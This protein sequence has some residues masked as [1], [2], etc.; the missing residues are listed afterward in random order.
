MKVFRYFA[1][2]IFALCA[3]SIVSA[4]QP[5][6]WTT[7]SVVLESDNSSWVRMARLKDGNWL[8][9]YTVYN[10]PKARIRIKKSLDNMR[11]WQF[12]TEVGEDG[13]D[14]DNPTLCVRQDGAVLLALRSVVVN[15]GFSFYINTYVSN[16]AGNSFAYQSQVEWDHGN[17]GV[18][19]PYLYALPDGKILCFYTSEIH[20]REPTPYSQILAEKVS[21]D[22]GSTWGPEIFAISQPGAARP[23]EANIVAL[24]GSVLALFYEICATENCVGH[25]SYS[26]DGVTWPGIGPAL[27]HTFQDV[28]AVGLDN[29]IIVATSNSKE[30]IVSVDYTNSWIDTKFRPFAAGSWPA[31]Y[32][33]GPNEISL[34]YTNGDDRERPGAFIRFGTINP[35]AIQTATSPG[36][37]RGPS[38]TRPQNCY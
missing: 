18:Y 27:A 7:Q 1:V 8:A 31:I 15:P 2:V 12:V 34:A 23:G 21:T 26:T 5:I 22:G 33:T 17:G 6:T 9:A 36:T 30:V 29:G 19:E 35:A 3:V 14:L 11:T 20:Q 16:D 32:Q 37:C 24:P 13:R 4:Q 28:Q 38:R 25:V 10:G